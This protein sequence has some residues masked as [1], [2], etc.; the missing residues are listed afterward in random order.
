MDRMIDQEIAR[1]HQKL[2]NAE[3]ALREVHRLIDELRI[4]L[5]EWL[6]RSEPRMRLNK[7]LSYQHPLSGAYR[8]LGKA[9]L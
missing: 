5:R 3:I 6:I 8:I 7:I 1:L 4:W 2:T 9:I